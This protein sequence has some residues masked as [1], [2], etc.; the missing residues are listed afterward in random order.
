M[1]NVWD[2]AA[3]YMEA[4]KR[5][6]RRNNW[7]DQP[8]HCELWSEKATVLRSMRPITE[9]WGVMLRACRG[10]GSTGME[11]QIGNLFESIHKPIT[12][13]YL[14]DHDP[15]GRDIERDI[16]HRAQ[17]ASGKE[18]E[19]RRLAIHAEDIQAFHLPPQRIK[20]TDS[21]AEA[22]KRKFGAG[23]ATVELDALPV[24]ELRRRV[25]DAIQERIDF[26]LWDRQVAIQEVELKSIADFAD[27]VKNLPQ[28]P[29]RMPD[30]ARRGNDGPLFAARFRRSQS[31]GRTGDSGR[32]PKIHWH[33]RGVGAAGAGKT[34]PK[35]P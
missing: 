29:D 2:D 10:F 23:A 24:E 19:M 7:Q 31:V 26:E 34:G 6:Y 4:V 11:G 32:S 12:V 15:S 25:R 18:F 9:D 14:G 16:H 21:R 8:N 33:P 35:N 27:T 5:S 3:G 1:V 17:D 22:F 30:E 28:A 13:F 20:I